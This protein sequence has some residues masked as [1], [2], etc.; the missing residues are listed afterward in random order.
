MNRSAY[1]LRLVEVLIVGPK[2]F[3]ADR[4][5]WVSQAQLRLAAVGIVKSDAVTPAFVTGRGTALPQVQ[6]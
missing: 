2:V 3:L 5:A 4:H 1:L 6:M